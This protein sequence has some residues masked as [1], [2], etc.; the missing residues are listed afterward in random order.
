MIGVIGS[1]EFPFDIFNSKI[2]EVFDEVWNCYNTCYRNGFA[3]RVVVTGDANGV[4]TYIEQWCKK[5]KIPVWSLD[6]LNPEIEHY[7]LCRNAE[8]VAL[9]KY[10]IAFWD[11]QSRGT[12]FTMDYAMHK[13]R[14]APVVLVEKNGEH[15]WL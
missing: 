7:F 5:N 8:I 3:E 9:S 4:D 1:R 6:C 2:K 13:K 10:I 12:K 15:R 11:G 14:H